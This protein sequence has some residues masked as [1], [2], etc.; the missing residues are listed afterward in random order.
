LASTTDSTHDR[1]PDRS[2]LAWSVICAASIAGY[3][4][5]YKAALRDGGN[6]S[7]VFALALVLASTINVARLG[8][9][10]FRAARALI[11]VRWR[12][13]LLMGTVCSGS[14]LI[15]MEALARGGSGYVLTLRNT[16]VL[17]ATVLAIVIG[18]RPRRTHV[19]G[20][21]LVAAGAIVMAWH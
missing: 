4:L 16:S 10:G 19:M 5:A 3:H 1:A 2:A 9:A 11:A 17:F 7:A 8:R 15:L 14:F 20:A 13:L 12:R 6:P 21:V 18:E